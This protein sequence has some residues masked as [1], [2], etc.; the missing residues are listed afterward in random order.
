VSLMAVKLRPFVEGEMEDKRELWSSRIGFILAT[1]GSAIGLG[2]IWK[3]PYEVGTNGGS[4]FILFYLL[5]IA[6]VVFPLM[7]VEFAVG[8]R[9]RADAVRSIADIAEE[10]NASR[11]WQLIGAAGIVTGF[12]ILSF[13]SV[14]GGW[15]LAYSVDTVLDGL[16]S[17]TVGAIQAR[18]DDLLASPWRM[19]TY[20]AL[21]MGMTAVIVARGIAG[22]IETACKVLMPV[23]MALIAV[24]AIYSMTEGD[25]PAAL[26]FLFAI[27]PSLVTPKV[28]L[29]ALGLGFFSIGVGLAVMITYAG[30][31]SSDIDLRAVAIA[32]IVGDTVIS[33]LAGLAVFPIVFAE[34]LDPAS[35]PGLM[36]VTLPL[37][38]AHLPFGVLAAIVFFVLLGI[39]ALASAISLLEMTV[40]FLQRRGWSRMFA[41]VISA[42]SCWVVGL[43]SVL[44][45]NLWK[46]WFP[47]GSIPAFERA[48]I[49][50][51]LD[52]LTSNILLPASGLALAIFGGWVLSAQILTDELHL[53]PQ[54]VTV[55]RSVLRYVV[56]FAIAAVLASLR[57]WAVSV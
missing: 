45:F 49:F 9:G 39:A 48:T 31:A 17:D 47:L 5:G 42:S 22:G 57:F 20:H 6:L 25:V 18:F 54:G 21:F 35:G 37:A 23:L 56:S 53:S 33:F 11:Q 29:E 14:I 3:F 15:A 32:T 40:A 4:A 52:Q 26:R 16:A 28:A 24:L 38:F 2:S 8:R 30:Y 12:L 46:D 36:F 44:S 41:T 50:D 43:A 51:L 1:I 27:N 7:L 55:L 10:S 19:A 13:Y 34:K